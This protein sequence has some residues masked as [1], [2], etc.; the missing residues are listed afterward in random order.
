MQHQHLEDRLSIPFIGNG[1]LTDFSHCPQ[2]ARH[3]TVSWGSL[4]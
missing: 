1:I 3:C 4:R 2:T